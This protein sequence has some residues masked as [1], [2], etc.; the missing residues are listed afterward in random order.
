[1]SSEEGRHWGLG[2]PPPPAPCVIE[3]LEP[4]LLL[5]GATGADL[6]VPF[7]P[8]QFFLSQ[9]GGYLTGPSPGEPLDVAMAYLAGHADTLGLQPADILQSAVTDLYT[10]ADTGVTHIYL[11]QQFGGLDVINANISVNVTADGRV[12][13]VGGGFVSGLGDMAAPA[14]DASLTAPAAL[15]SAGLAVGL[16]STAESLVAERT[17]GADRTMVLINPDL[18]LDPIPAKLHYVAGPDG[19]RLAWDLVMRTADLQHWYEVSVDATTGEC[20]HMIDWVDAASYNVYAGPTESPDE[21]S[22]TLLTDPYDPIASPFGWHDTNAAAGPEYTDTRGNN[23]FAQEDADHNNTGGFRPDGGAGLNFDYTLNLAQSPSSYQAAAITNLFYWN[24]YLHDLHYHYGF[25]E[26]SGNFQMINYTG[27]GL[28]N[29]AVQADAQDGGSTNNANFAT[30][31]DG[32]SPRM[33]MYLFTYGTP[34]RDADLDSQIIIH[35]YGHG[36]STRLVGGPANSG[37]LGARQ[38]GAMGEGWCDWWA[39]MLTMKSADSRTVAYPLAAY[40]LGHAPDGPGLRRYPY[41]FDMSINPL[42]YGDYGGN[43]EVHAAGEIWCSALWDMTWLLVGK[44]GFSGNYALG[45]D[46][47]APGQN[48]G[49]A[50]ALKLV[51]DSLKL[52]PAN[53][54]F[55]D[56]R[57]A[58]LQADLVLTGG[59]NSN[60]IWAAFAR[61]GMGLGAGDGGSANSTYVT[62][63]FDTPGNYPVVVSSTPSG[64]AAGTPISQITLRFNKA[65]D[66]ASFSLADDVASFTGPGGVNLKPAVT[67]AAWDGPRTLL[68]TFAPQTTPGPYAMTIGPWILSAGDGMP[69]DQDR[70]GVPGEA[71]DDRYTAAFDGAAVLYS[72]DMST[73]PG[74]SLDGGAA[75]NQWLY[76]VPGG[77]SGDPSSGHT[78]GSVIG[79]N[80]QGNYPDQM[81]EAQYATT[82]AFSTVGYNDVTVS[83][84]Q[85]LGVEASIYDHAGIEVWDGAA[86]TALWD[87]TGP[88]VSPASWSY[89]RHVLPAS[90]NDRPEVKLRWAMGPSDKYVNYCGWNIDDVLVWGTAAGSDIV[91]PSAAAIVPD[92]LTGAQS[93]VEFRFDE[94]MDTTSFSVAEDVVSFT[95]P[96]GDLK[97]S[98]TGYQ[99]LDGQTL[100]VR[101]SVQTA[102]GSYTMVIG[103]NIT[104]NGPSFNPMDQ[105]RDGINGEA[106]DDRCGASFTI[107]A[108]LGVL[109]SADMSVDPGWTFDPGTGPF[110]WE[111]GVPAGVGGDPTSGHTGDN[112]IGYDLNGQYPFSMSATQYATTPA[113]STVGYTGVTLGFWVWL[114]V[115]DARYDHANIQVWNGSAWLAVWTHTGDTITSGNR[116]TYRRFV[117]PDSVSNQPAVKIRWGMGPTDSA[118][119]YC[120]WNIDDVLVTGTPT[121]APAV[122]GRY[123]FYNNSVFDGNNPTAG[124]GDDGA[125]APPPS[126]Y[127]PAETAKQLGKQALLPGQTAS[128]VNHTNYSRGIN[129]IMVDIVGLAGRAVTAADFA[130]KVGNSSDTSQWAPA[131]APLSVTVRRGAGA[132]GS[133]RVTIIWA[134]DDPMTSQR[135]PGAISN[136]WLQVVV[137]ANASGGSL[138]LARDDVFYFGNAIGET[139][140]SDD[141]AK[142]NATDILAA[143][144]HPH[145]AS[146]PATIYDAY[147]FDRDGLVNSESAD[148]AVA[149]ANQT[150]FL[151]ALQLITAPATAG[152]PAAIG[153]GQA[154]AQAQFIIGD[155]TR[156]GLVNVADLMVVM[157]NLG[158]TGAKWEQ[159]DFDGNGVVDTADYLALKAHFGQS[160][161][162]A[163]ASPATAP[164]SAGTTTPVS[165]GT[166][167][168]AG[169][170]GATTQLAP[171]SGETTAQAGEPG[172]QPASDEPDPP[173]GEPNEQPVGD[174]IPATTDPS[175]EPPETPAAVEQPAPPNDAGPAAATDLDLL[176]QAAAITASGMGRPARGP[177]S[178]SFTE[179]R[180]HGLAMSGTGRPARGPACRSFTEG[181][182][183]GL[184]MSPTGPSPM[185][186]PAVALA[187]AGGT[188]IP[189]RGPKDP[190]MPLLAQPP[191]YAWTY[192]N[193]RANAGDAPSDEST[194]A[195]PLLPQLRAIPWNHDLQ[196]ERLRI[197]RRRSLKQ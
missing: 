122:V 123:I 8:P 154:Q 103:P 186:L 73:D 76:G 90:A 72:A 191:T 60:M 128:L 56:G 117:L 65:I 32:Q 193:L 10:S 156:D 149:S 138:G 21:G 6:S 197:G 115:E 142:V 70:D 63:A 143:R 49:N 20:L 30:P 22:R 118:A 104:D 181:R 105:D 44:Y 161:P 46:A 131:P 166:T 190:P 182:W 159:G 133:D 180:W 174:P 58:L 47:A 25:D 116:F 99:W 3:A 109:Y 152:A 67:G 13:N 80:L 194:L 85:W 86:W 168:Q 77:L 82:P 179:G 28:G 74:W 78:G 173:P 68:I 167:A 183:H 4:R 92:S 162:L 189:V 135:E 100:E 165:A 62:E 178:R 35:E 125:I 17:D 163:P 66:P 134:D 7:L 59:A 108:G 160:A 114:G 175:G 110:K 1:M 31:P 14:I 144:N 48:G 153:G 27:Q 170:T 124:A 38:S 96:A 43:P 130:F 187:K 171:P 19:V 54:S 88:D 157:A 93:R 45:Y 169:T 150:N 81:A 2:C 55:L 9:P 196:N 37:A 148:E 98:I 176:A 126:L 12:L 112:V 113:F 141:G 192:A 177:A 188:G 87:Y 184:A 24:N 195:D 101:F 33:Q 155:A 136:Q 147:D 84:W 121:A 83:F 51:E 140:D 139:G 29:D 119:S 95:G 52:M 42:T 158:A 41:S 50:L 185:S 145:L 57:D 39:L 107:V 61:R 102:T 23:V 137:L 75:P 94:M 89:A 172:E 129:G 16:P 36:V 127:D 64:P 69:M 111:Y 40:S 15:V 34:A 53:P 151:T 97:G 164:A 5:T 146:N 11:R 132:N 26:A 91:G 120:G 106:V 18:S 71:L 79:Y